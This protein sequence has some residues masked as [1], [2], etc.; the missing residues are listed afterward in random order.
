MFDTSGSDTGTRTIEIMPRMLPHPGR[1]EHMGVPSTA[2]RGEDRAAGFGGHTRNFGQAPSSV[3]AMRPTARPVI[4][5]PLE[6]S[7]QRHRFFMIQLIDLIVVEGRCCGWSLRAI[8]GK[9]TSFIVRRS[10][11]TA[12]RQDL[13]DTSNAMPPR[14]AW[15]AYRR[16]P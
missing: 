9:F 2:S 6:K 13:Q 11:R 8:H 16:R 7:L 15:L 4:L 1:I 5:T 14:N 3:L 10:A 12:G